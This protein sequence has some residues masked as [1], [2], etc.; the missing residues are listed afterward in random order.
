M[1]NDVFLRGLFRRD[2]M[3]AATMLM[4]PLDAAE[5]AEGFEPRPITDTDITKVQEY[6]QRFF[7][8]LPR[9]IIRDAAECAADENRFHPVREWLESL[10]WDGKPRLETWLAQYFGADDSDY[11]RGI[12]PMFLISMVAR[13]FKPGEKVDHMLWPT[14]GLR[15]AAVLL[16]RDNQRG[17]LPEGPDRRSKILA[18]QVR[19]D[20]HRRLEA[21][22]RPAI[23]RGRSPVQ[24]QDTMVAG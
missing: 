6:L 17:R 19:G 24:G 12:G 22:P 20:R 18:G 16:C 9:D 21:R 23:R 2:E 4:K 1:R 8:R 13:I 5:G 10:Q 15:E 11:I 3:M 14:R 7:V